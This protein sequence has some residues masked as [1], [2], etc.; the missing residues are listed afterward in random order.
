LGGSG[1]Y[2]FRFW[3]DDRKRL[4][5]QL[6]ANMGFYCVEDKQARFLASA[7][8]AGMDPTGTNGRANGREM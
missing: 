3:A 2:V 8:M 1:A 4:K 7:G 6:T 5:L